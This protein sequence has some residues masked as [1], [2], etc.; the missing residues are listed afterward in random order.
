M[1]QQRVAR[2]EKA[3]GAAPP[4]PAVEPPTFE[5][6]EIPGNMLEDD[7]EYTPSVWSEVEEDKDVPECPPPSDGDDEI[8]EFEE[9][10]HSGVNVVL[11]VSHDALSC[12]APEELAQETYSSAVKANAEGCLGAAAKPERLQSNVHKSPGGHMLFEF[13]CASDSSLGRICEELGVQ[14]VR[15]C[16]EHY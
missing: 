1:V 3:F 9:R 2:Y 16:K 15:L 5:M 12:S 11:A 14:V 13:A 8:E 7:Q 10:V 6:P 4:A